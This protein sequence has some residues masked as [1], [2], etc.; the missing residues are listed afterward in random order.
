MATPSTINTLNNFAKG[1][2]NEQTN[3]FSDFLAPVVTTGAATFNVIDYAKR[4]GFQVPSGARAIGGDSKAVQSDGERVQISLKPYGL[5]DTIDTFELDQA[6][7]SGVKLMRESRVSNLISQS[8]N[9]KF[10][11]TLDVVNGVVTT[12]AEV[13]GGSE[14]P[15][16]DIDAQ[17]LAIS[18]KTGKMPNRIMMSLTAWSIFRNNAAVIARQPGKDQVSFTVEQASSMFLNPKMKIM[19]VDTVFDTRINVTSSKANAMAGDVYIFFA[20]DDSNVYDNSF[21]KTFRIQSN[22]F[23]S[24]RVSPKDYGEKIM[25]DWTEVVYVNNPDMGVRLQVTES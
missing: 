22:P 16:K 1:L 10:K 17:I 9:S 24:V 21:T 5:H 8:S 25:V 15:I 23:Q 2:F 13:W 18:N 14:D 11:D 7:T 20:Q 4:S 3:E 12:V 19:I 6:G